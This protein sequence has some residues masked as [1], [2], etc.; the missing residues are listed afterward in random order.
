[1]WIV[2][3]RRKGQSDARLRRCESRMDF[4]LRGG[5]AARDISRVSPDEDR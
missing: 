4:A 5:V 3:G 2:R 1:M